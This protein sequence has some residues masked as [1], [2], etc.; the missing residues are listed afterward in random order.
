MLNFDVDS[1]EMD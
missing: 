1:D